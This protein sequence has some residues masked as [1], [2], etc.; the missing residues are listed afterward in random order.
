MNTDWGTVYNLTV[1]PIPMTSDY[2]LHNRSEDAEYLVV[3]MQDCSVCSEPEEAVD[4]E[5]TILGD[6]DGALEVSESDNE[7]E[8]MEIE[9]AGIEGG[10]QSGSAS[11]SEATRR[12]IG[13]SHEDEEAKEPLR[14]TESNASEQG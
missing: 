9:E 4:N 11:H 8:F 2:A 1:N 14:H 13:S 6:Q 10:P 12:R 7:F 5:K 3:A